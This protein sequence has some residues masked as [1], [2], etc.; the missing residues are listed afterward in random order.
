VFQESHETT[1]ASEMDNKPGGADRVAVNV[2]MR[3][4]SP[5]HDRWLQFGRRPPGG[6]RRAA[7]VSL[8]SSLCCLFWTCCGWAAETNS[9]EQPPRA[10]ALLKTLDPFYKQHLVADGLLIVGSEKVSQYALR[11]VAYLARKM[12]ANRPDV[13]KVMGETRR[14]Y[15]CVMAYNEMQTDLPEC[16]GLGPWWDYRARGLAGGSVSCGEE[17]VLCFP[18]DPWQGENIFIHEFAHGIHGVLAGMDKGF[19]ARVEA[20]HHEA[21]QSGRFRGYAIEGGPGEFWAEG[22]QAW[23]NCN[24]T[25]RPESGGG[26]S[27]FEVLGPRGEHVCHITTREQLKTHLPK[28]A[29]LLDATFRQNQ[30][31][32]VPV[33]KR[34]DDPHLRGYDPAKAPT[35]RWPPE[36]IEAFRRAEA[37][38]AQKRQ[39]HE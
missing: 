18:G 2:W 27:S 32:Y 15:V 4:G 3:A 37:E 9:V 25:I 31:V 34:L 17:N 20:L 19:N 12:L 5:R 39:Q 13:M 7:I 6:R 38:K 1:E 16:R 23:F 10:E 36:V 22:V 28:F 29:K 35:F 11:E 14:M 26:Q 33:A 24:G 8:A 30:W 21:K